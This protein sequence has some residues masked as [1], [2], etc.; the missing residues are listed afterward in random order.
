MGRQQFEATYQID[1]ILEP[2]LRGVEQPMVRIRPAQRV[3][4]RYGH[5]K[6]AELEG[7]QD[8]KHRPSITPRSVH[9]SLLL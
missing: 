3:Q 4:R 1:G 2:V 8:Q 7:P 6:V 9:S 5:E